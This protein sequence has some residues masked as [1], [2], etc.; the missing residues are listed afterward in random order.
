MVGEARGHG[1][2]GR[3]VG[4]FVLA[5]SNLAG[6]MVVAFVGFFA[7][8]LRCDDNCSIA[9]GWRN[10][11]HA[12]QW[13]GTLVLSLVILGSA[14]WCEGGIGSAHRGQNPLVMASM[15][16]GFA[17]IGDTQHLPGYSLLLAD[18]SSLDHLTELAWEPRQQFLFDL[19][20]IGE[21]GRVAAGRVF[22][23]A[24]RQGMPA[25]ERLTTLELWSRCG[26]QGE[27]AS[28]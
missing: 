26:S 1:S 24:P 6:A 4:A 5:L 25:S 3:R 9:P 21:A 20:L 7:D 28:S 10:D 13:R 19:S 2:G 15:R 23:N 18:D 22:T 12:W 27:R 8:G 16:S 17:V 14:D 11:P